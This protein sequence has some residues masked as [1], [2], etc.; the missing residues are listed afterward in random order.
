MPQGARDECS[1]ALLAASMAM[2]W[3]GWLPCA[4]L[5]GRAA[6]PELRPPA[7][8]RD[9]DGGASGS[10]QITSGKT[11][12]LIATIDPFWVSNSMFYG[13]TAKK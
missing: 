8:L 11:T 10:D 7:A 2:G 9:A 12:A 6:D 1:H 4:P 3:I 5:A 13:V